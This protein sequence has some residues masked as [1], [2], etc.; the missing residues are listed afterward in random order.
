MALSNDRATIAA[1]VDGGTWTTLFGGGG[2]EPVRQV[3]LR[4]DA[5]SS[6]AVTFEVTSNKEDRVQE[7]TLQPG[8]PVAEVMALDAQGE[9]AI[10]LVRAQSVD[11]DE[12]AVGSQW[13]SVI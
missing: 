1:N 6:Y 2:E 11:A 7:I 12:T 8:D 9:G 10:T 13:V 5:S 4:C 3:A